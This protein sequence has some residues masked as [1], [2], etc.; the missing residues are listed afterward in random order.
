MSSPQRTTDSLQDGPAVRA[1]FIFLAVAL[2]MTLL[3]GL[4]G[5]P[6]LPE[7]VAGN[8]SEA[9]RKGWLAQHES[10]ASESNVELP[11]GSDLSSESHQR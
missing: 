3:L 10:Q 8:G 7:T 9:L 5:V 2:V 4:A 11:E 6:P 1:E